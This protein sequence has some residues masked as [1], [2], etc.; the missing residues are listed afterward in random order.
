MTPPPTIFEGQ[1]LQPPWVN[2]GGSPGAF[3][4]STESFFIQGLV[5]V[6]CMKIFHKH[7]VGTGKADGKPNVL[8]LDEHASHLTFEAVEL[9]MPINTELF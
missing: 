2:G 4:A 5:F 9:A 7:I 3:Y 6:Q 1:R 8:V